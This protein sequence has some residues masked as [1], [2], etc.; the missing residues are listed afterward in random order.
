MKSM[1]WWTAN[2]KKSRNAFILLFLIAMLAFASGCSIFPKEAEEEDI[3]VIEPPKI[4]KKPEMV[5]ARGDLVVP[6]KGSGKVYS[7]T[8]EFLYFTGTEK[9][10]GT[11]GNGAQNETFRIKKVYVEQGQQV[12][13]GDLLAELETRDLDLKVEKSANQLKIDEYQ[14]IQKLREEVNTIEEQME[15]EQVKAAFRDKQIEHEKLVRQLQNSRVVAPIDG[16]VFQVYYSSGDQVKAYDPVVLIIDTKDLVVGISITETEQKSLTLGQAVS[17]EISGKTY[18]GKIEKFPSGKKETNDP[19]NPNFRPKDERNDK[20]LI[21]VEG[22]PAEIQR[23]TTAN[24]TIVLQEKKD[25]IK[26]P[27]SFLHTYG[28]RN[29]V[30]VTDDQGKREVDVELGLRSAREVEIVEGVEAGVTIIG[31]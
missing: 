12:K 4:S 15:L 24:G 2:Y 18:Q 28:E 11:G 19:W 1:K 21:S 27:L 25:V 8:E 29:Y 13:Q 10:D 5:V 30:I 6:A 17:V 22:L 7:N 26:I 23:G 3:P 31:R 16:T 9:E 14:L 20:V